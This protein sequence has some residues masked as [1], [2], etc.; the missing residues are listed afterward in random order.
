MLISRK[1]GEKKEDFN[2]SINIHFLM[3]LAKTHAFYR[4][5]NEFQITK[6]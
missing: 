4:I 5:G 2:L 3:T 6:Q 1:I